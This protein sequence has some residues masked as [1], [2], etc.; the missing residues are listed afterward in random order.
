VE[1]GKV[2][3]WKGGKVKKW[4]GGKVKRNSAAEERRHPACRK[5]LSAWHT[6]EKYST[7]RHEIN[8]G[9]K[10]KGVKVIKEEGWKGVKEKKW[11]GTAQQ[12][13]AGILPA[14]NDP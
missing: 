4:K 13:N 9:K 3:K 1:K 12:R 5:G 7:M 2:K 6:K 10:C 14:G 11:K 8:E